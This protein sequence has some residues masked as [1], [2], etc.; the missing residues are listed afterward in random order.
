MS[1]IFYFG[2]KRHEKQQNFQF[3]KRPFLR[4]EWPY[5]HD[6][7]R[8]YREYCKYCKASKKIIW[9]FFSKYSKS[10]NILNAKSY[11]KL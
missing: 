6:F 11:L 1:T 4:N 3:F 7:R 5:G 9:Q 8:V 2:N 10:Y